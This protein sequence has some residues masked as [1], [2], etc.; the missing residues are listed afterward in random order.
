V[1]V[2]FAPFA[3]GQP[4]P[5]SNANVGGPA[6]CTTQWGDSLAS[7]AAR[8]GMDLPPLVELNCLKPTARLKLG[9]ELRIDSPH[10]VPRRLDDGIIINVPHRVLFYFKSGKPAADCNSSARRIRGRLAGSP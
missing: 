2:R 3:A 8:F 6:D 9:Q 5:L 7:V 10:L 1:V 4:I